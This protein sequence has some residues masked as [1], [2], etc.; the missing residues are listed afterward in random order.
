ML[1]QI[2][3]AVRKVENSRF[4]AVEQISRQL[5]NKITGPFEALAGRHRVPDILNRKQTIPPIADDAV[6]RDPDTY[7]DH[8]FRV[9]PVIEIE[10]PQFQ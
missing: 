9:G 2:V 3:G 7:G 5:G 6:L 10:A 8:V 4:H 1:L